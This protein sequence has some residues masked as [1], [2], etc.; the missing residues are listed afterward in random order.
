MVKDLYSENYKIPLK[1]V[2]ETNKSKYILCSWVGRD[3]I[4]KKS[5]LPLYYYHFVVYTDVKL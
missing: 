5:I 3:N 2:E 4:I 1:E